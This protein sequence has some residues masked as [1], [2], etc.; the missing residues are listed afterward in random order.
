MTTAIPVLERLFFVVIVLVPLISG[1][2]VT[3]KKRHE[4]TVGL[5]A[6]AF[7]MATALVLGLSFNSVAKNDY[8]KDNTQ[9][10]ATVKVLNWYE[11]KNQEARTTVER[12][13]VEFITD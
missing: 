12:W 8:Q 4:G 11:G 9:E 10:T 7:L 13:L 3:V 6:G 2:V 5:R 1:I